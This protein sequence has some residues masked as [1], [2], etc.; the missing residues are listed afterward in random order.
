MV[1]HRRNSP[2]SDGQPPD[3]SANSQEVPARACPI[4]RWFG[5]DESAY[6]VLPRPLLTCMPP[7]W[8]SSFIT[9]VRQ[10]QAAY[11]D[12]EQ[13][14]HYR[15]EAGEWI[16][17]A[18][19]P[20]ICLSDLGIPHDP[21]QTPTAADD[22]APPSHTEPGRTTTE[23]NL[24]DRNGLTFN[25]LTNH[26]FIPREDPSLRMSADQLHPQLNP[27]SHTT[28]AGSSP[29]SSQHITTSRVQAT[30]S[31]SPGSDSPET[32]KPSDD[33]TADQAPPI[34]QV[35]PLRTKGNRRPPV[36]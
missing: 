30:A 5:H 3:S 20:E 14:P 12:V 13:A 36:A 26:L 25:T 9:L 1:G 19:L 18:D 7:E 33:S 24:L 29:V 11:L 15:V 16:S 17:V 10:F 28:Q 34:A 6:L 35:I 32:T 8:Q 4:D 27:T 21:S 22:Y 31:G 2:T 23:Q